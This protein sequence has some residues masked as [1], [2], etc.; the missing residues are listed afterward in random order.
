MKFL[1]NPVIAFLLC[2]LLILTSTCLNAK[3]KMERRYDRICDELYDEV[4]DFADDNGI[5][6]LKVRARE[7]A[8]KGDYRALIDAFSELSGSRDYD[9]ADDVD[10]EIR[11][12][13]K[14]LR[15]TQQFPAKIFVD[16]LN[17]TF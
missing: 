7:A 17:I 11:A 2:L 14:F 10:E 3:V 13:T 15:K 8:S 6:E 1:K 5:A 12:Y 4:L 9:D 16:L